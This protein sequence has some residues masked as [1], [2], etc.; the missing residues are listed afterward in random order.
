M[1]DNKIK[2]LFFHN[3]IFDLKGHIMSNKAL[4]VYLFS[5]NKRKANPSPYASP[6]LHVRF[7]ARF[8]LKGRGTVPSFALWM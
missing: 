6:K 1:N 3:M 8:P 4:Y 2:T 7:S 5:S